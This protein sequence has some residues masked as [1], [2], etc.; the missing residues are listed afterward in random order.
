MTISG[1]EYYF[2]R[3]KNKNLRA[4]K[5]KKK[6]QIISRII[7]RYARKQF[8]KEIILHAQTAHRGIDGR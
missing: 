3:F 1:K 5:F 6:G 7:F 4:K 8:E 2:G